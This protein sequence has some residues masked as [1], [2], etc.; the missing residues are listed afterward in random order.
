[1]SQLKMAAALLA[2]LILSLSAF[3]QRPEPYPFVGAAFPSAQ[4]EAMSAEELLWNNFL[5]EKWCIVSVNSEKSADLP[6][7]T[8]RDGS[9]VSGE[10][11]AADSFN[12]FLWNI[13][14]TDENR[15]YRIAG[16]DWVVFVHSRP[17]LEVLF[18]RYKANLNSNR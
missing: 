8:T 5:S 14:L 11:F 9:A 2:G 3:S 1:M 6:V 18:D 10:A 13:E 12:P 15:Y 7:L 16:S 17:R 4:I